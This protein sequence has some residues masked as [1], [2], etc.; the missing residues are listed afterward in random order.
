[1]KQW[2]KIFKQKGKV[3]I[4][5]EKDIPKIAQLFKRRSIKKVLDLGCGSGR[6]LVYLAKHDFEV[7]G[8]D[9]APAGIKIAKDWLKKEKLRAKLML[10]KR[11]HHEV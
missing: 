6:H 11:R 8:I 3:F 2:D 9:I 1:M 7:Y 10:Q 5:V 4:R